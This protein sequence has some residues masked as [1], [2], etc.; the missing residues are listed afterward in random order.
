VPRPRRTWLRPAP[1]LAF[2]LTLAACG[3]SS[4]G[5][6]GSTT[7]AGRPAVA[8]TPF[9]YDASRPL[10]VRDAG[11][12]NKDYPIVLRDVSF[13]SPGGRVQGFLAL[14][15]GKARRPGVVFVHGS[16][17]DRGQLLVQ[18]M[19]LAG[20]GSVTLAITAPSATAPPGTSQG[21]TPVQGLRRQRDLAIRDVVAVRRAVDLLRSRP[22]VDGTRLGYV[23]WSAGART[24]ALVA[25][26][27]RRL[28]AFVLM[29]GGAT[30]VSAYAAQAPAELRDDVHRLLG[31]VDPLRTIGKARPG[32][33]LLQD[34]RQDTVVPRAALEDLAAA[35][36]HGTEIRWY[37]A[38]HELDTKAYRD[39]LDWLAGKLA[40]HGRVR[41]ALTGP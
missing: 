24:G 35:T 7:T 16:G 13:A 19:W 12:A 36:P 32:T 23:G 11:R 2:C 39:Q 10:A 21:L 30:P 1:L 37:D 18:A 8:P 26:I 5:E 29:S 14:P 3:G 25:G 17:G 38:G 6:A 40:I 20:R 27:E 15:P 28:G 41:G 22:E 34:G 9:D 33:L 4:S 31:P